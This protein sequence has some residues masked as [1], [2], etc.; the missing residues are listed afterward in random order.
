MNLK[1]GGTSG[2]FEQSQTLNEW[3]QDVRESNHWPE[4][5]VT[6]AFNRV[7]DGSSVVKVWQRKKS[8]TV[9]IGVMLCED[10]YPIYSP[11][12]P[13]VCIGVAEAKKTGKETNW[14]IWT[15]SEWYWAKDDGD[16]KESGEAHDFGRPPFEFFGDGKS[17]LEDA[18]LDQNE[19]IHR[20]SIRLAITQSQGFS[21][22]QVNGE[23]LDEGTQNAYQV[24]GTGPDR[25][26]VFRD[27]NGS[28]NFVNPDAPLDEHRLSYEDLLTKSFRLSLRLPGDLISGSN[29]VEQPT[30]VQWHWMIS[31]IVYNGLVIEGES[32]EGG[33][34]D[35]LAPIASTQSGVSFNTEELDYEHEFHQS[36]IP[37]ES[38]EERTKDQSDVT[39]GRMHRAHYVAKW[40]LPDASPEEILA[41]L[42]A[43]E[44]EREAQ[45]QAATKIPDRSA[46][47]IPAIQNRVNGLGK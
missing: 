39:S 34:T 18:L 14:R 5:S 15:T 26:F 37:T 17:M 46:P 44:A 31:K 32:L 28:I 47:G 23:P 8:E 42:D 20:E 2:D 7:R 12:D 25:T 36:P 11:E 10:A 13:T 40:I 4:Q 16:I 3:F 27:E 43:L 45:M 22:L 21:Y 41:Y 33:L 9:G 19:L 38:S 30:T 24:H 1:S 29:G 35:I 6:A